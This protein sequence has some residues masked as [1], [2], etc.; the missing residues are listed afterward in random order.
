VTKWMGR[1]M[2]SIFISIQSSKM[3]SS[4]RLSIIKKR[5]LFLSEAQRKC[6]GNPIPKNS[7][8]ENT[9]TPAKAG[10][11]LFPTDDVNRTLYANIFN[12]TC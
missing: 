2:I 4:M 1:Y 8:Y 7:G 11:M 12:G 10:A 9:S 6:A 3:D 5:I